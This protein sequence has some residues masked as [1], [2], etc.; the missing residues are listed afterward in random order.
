MFSWLEAI[1]YTLV[2]LAKINPFNAILI[3]S[4]VSYLC[5]Q[6]VRT[7]RKPLHDFLQVMKGFID[8]KDIIKQYFMD[9]KEALLHP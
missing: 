8:D 5:Y 4:F 1:Y 7:I 3:V 2:Q 6:G 9:K